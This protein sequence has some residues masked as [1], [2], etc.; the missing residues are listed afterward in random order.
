MFI[1]ALDS[2]SF[3][4]ITEINN[5][6]V[7]NGIFMTI[8]MMVPRDL[9]ESL[10]D[11]RGLERWKHRAGHIRVQAQDDN[12]GHRLA[13]GTPQQQKLTCAL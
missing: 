8:T 13:L 10:F 3:M 11:I 6:F 9:V 2:H 4:S 7:Q 5:Y 1:S 12:T